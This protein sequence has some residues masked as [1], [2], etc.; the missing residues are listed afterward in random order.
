M[1]NLTIFILM[2][3]VFSC[4]YFDKQKVTSLDILKEELKTFNWN[5][6][7][8]YP[9][10]EVCEFSNSSLENK[11]CFE[12][13]LIKHITNRLSKKNIIVTDNVEDTIMMN[14]HIS[15]LGILSVS[16]IDYKRKTKLQIPNIESLLSNS[17]DSLPTIHPALK[18]GQQVKTEFNLP[19]VIRVN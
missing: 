19:I 10:F 14:F 11:K 6:I 3:N 1:R 8:N 7:D 5:N 16:K 2:L 17:I 15:E 12:T 9:S 18:R 13:N 4:Q